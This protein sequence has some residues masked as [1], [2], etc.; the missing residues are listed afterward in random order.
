MIFHFSAAG[1][2][3]YAARRAVRRIL[4]GAVGRRL[5]HHLRYAGCAKSRRNQ[6]FGSYGFLL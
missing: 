5:P 1:D 6:G 3:P 4:R 2:T